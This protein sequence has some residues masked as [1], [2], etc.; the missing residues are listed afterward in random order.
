MPALN[1]MLYERMLDSIA[2]TRNKILS[3]V[4]PSNSE[5]KSVLDEI[6]LGYNAGLSKN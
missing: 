1:A 4:D 5:L 6:E 3:A 2:W